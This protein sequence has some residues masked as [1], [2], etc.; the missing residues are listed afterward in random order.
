MKLDISNSVSTVSLLF[1]KE[2][3]TRNLFNPFL[4]IQ[5]MEFRVGRWVYVSIWACNFKWNSMAFGEV[6]SATIN[7]A[8]SFSSSSNKTQRKIKIKKIIMEIEQATH[9]MICYLY[10]STPITT[11]DD[12]EKRVGSQTLFLASVLILFLSRLT[13][14][15]C[16][17]L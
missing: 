2:K 12:D 5:M 4:K 11:L 3:H 6:T 15:F 17:K 7:C 8:P 14:S 1:A 10:T 9:N 16:S 13:F